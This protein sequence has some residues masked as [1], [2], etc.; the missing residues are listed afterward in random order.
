M[1]PRP[2]DCLGAG[3][4]IVGSAAML[5]LAQANPRVVL[6]EPTRDFQNAP[7]RHRQEFPGQ[8]GVPTGQLPRETLRSSTRALLRAFWDVAGFRQNQ[9]LEGGYRPLIADHTLR[10]VLGWNAN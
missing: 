6:V 9:V 5:E 3:T 8:P 2:R 4:A 10:D 7:E 1:Q